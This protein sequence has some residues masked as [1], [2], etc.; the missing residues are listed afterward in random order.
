MF[1]KSNSHGVQSL[2]N[3]PIFLNGDSEKDVLIFRRTIE[4][5]MK[6]GYWGGFVGM[7]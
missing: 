3:E 7:S 1:S 6:L 2:L 5:A 4:A